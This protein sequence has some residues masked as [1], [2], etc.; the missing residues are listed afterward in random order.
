MRPIYQEMDESYPI[1]STKTY[2]YNWKTQNFDLDDDYT[3]RIAFNVQVD[4]LENTTEEKFWPYVEELKAKK[5]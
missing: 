3:L 4:E 5:R 1:I 2:V